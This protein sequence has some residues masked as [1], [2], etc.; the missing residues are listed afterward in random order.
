MAD[1][2]RQLL[3]LRKESARLRAALR[4]KQ[5]DKKKGARPKAAAKKSDKPDHGG[6]E[7]DANW[8]SAEAVKRDEERKDVPLTHAMWA[9]V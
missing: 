5:L 9:H 8:R 1:A 3:L 7:G 6:E 4:C 2:E